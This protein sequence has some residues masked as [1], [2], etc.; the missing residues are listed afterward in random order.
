MDKAGNNIGIICKTFYLNIL[1]KEITESGNFEPSNTTYEISSNYTD[2][3]KKLS[4]QQRYD[5]NLPFVYWIP[6]FHK[7]PVSFRYITC[8]R[9]TCINGLSKILS[10]A[11]KCILEVAKRYSYKIHRFDYI[12][13]YI[14]T[15]SN[16]D[17]LNYVYI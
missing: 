12:Q 10:T 2:I 11:L 17:S 6:K 5:A 13:D 1:Y 3:L 8:G 4:D 15:D 14:I 9:K 7:V 16:K